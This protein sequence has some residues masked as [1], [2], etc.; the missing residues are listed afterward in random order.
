[1]R[2]VTAAGGSSLFFA[3]APGVVAGLVPW[4]LT[5]WDVRYGSARSAAPAQVAGAVLLAACTVVLVQAF[6]R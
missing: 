5:G 2:R 6:V 1:M 3:A 4:A